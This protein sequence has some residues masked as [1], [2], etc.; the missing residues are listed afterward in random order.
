[1]KKYRT[2]ITLGVFAAAMGILEAVVVVYLRLLYYPAGF[3]FPLAP[4]PGGTLL[5]EMVRE[6]ATIAML[7][8]A[9]ALA[10][11]TWRRKFAYFCFVFGAWDIFYYLGLELFL[12][13]PPSLLTWDV[14]F[15]IP[16]TWVG[17][18]LAPV[19]CALTLAAFALCAAPPGEEGREPEITGGQLAAMGLGAAL[20]FCTFVW[21]YAALIVRNGYLRAFFTL[22]RNEEFLRLSSGY[23]PVR[24]N[25]PLF[26]A[27]EALVLGAIALFL[28]RSARA[29]K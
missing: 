18:V 22:A 7:A 11:G 25:W 23:V 26:A 14:L 21:D 20:V 17:P 2:Y 10:G 6:A 19:I 15:L 13:W 1:M 24:Y 29:G 27:G 28:K 8:C 4:I 3:G 5:T 12:G 9:G 16:V